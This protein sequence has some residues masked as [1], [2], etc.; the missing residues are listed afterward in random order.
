MSL[1]AKSG[2]LPLL[3]IDIFRKKTLTNRI[4]LYIISWDYLYLSKK[5]VGDVTIPTQVIKYNQRCSRWLSQTD[6]SIHIKLIIVILILTC[7]F[8]FIII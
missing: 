2:Y 4:Y 6:C 7:N 8:F 5:Y 3:S 1:T